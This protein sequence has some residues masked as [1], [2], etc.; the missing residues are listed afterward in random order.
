MTMFALLRN[1]AFVVAA[2]GIGASMV[3]ADTLR[4]GTE[5]AYGAVQFGFRER[6]A[7][8]F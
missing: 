3:Q 6:R 1:S 8:W 2:F 7:P 4:L 5:G